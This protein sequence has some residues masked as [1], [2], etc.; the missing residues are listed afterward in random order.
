[1]SATRK[2]S[3]EFETR[4]TT[5]NSSSSS[6]QNFVAR[7]I[8]F[9]SDIPYLRYR[10]FQ[11]RWGGKAPLEVLRT[12]TDDLI[13]L[14]QT[15]KIKHSSDSTDVISWV[16]SRDSFLVHDRAR[17]LRFLES[18]SIDREVFKDELPISSFRFG[19]VS[20]NERIQIAES[21]L[22]IELESQQKSLLLELANS[23]RKPNGK[24]LDRLI[25]SLLNHHFTT[26][27]ILGSE[28]HRGLL[29]LGV[30]GQESLSDAQMHQ[31][32]RRF[33]VSK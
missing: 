15:S 21:L 22:H 32:K 7:S 4:I 10:I 16:P 30:L 8:R 18:E 13:Y 3:E 11:G 1:L 31:L 27:Q 29:A 14:C 24:Q 23:R 2:E 25:Q 26:K 9:V 20:G 19:P 5:E 28:R 6:A 33:A 12:K 17:G